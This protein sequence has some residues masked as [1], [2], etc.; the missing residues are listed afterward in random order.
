MAVRTICGSGKPGQLDRRGDRLIRAG[1]ASLAYKSWMRRASA[2]L[3][4]SVDIETSCLNELGEPRSGLLVRAPAEGGP[5][6]VD[7][8]VGSSGPKI[9]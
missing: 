4:M 7:N 2:S 3:R 1:C 8:V 6:G 9:V 5:I